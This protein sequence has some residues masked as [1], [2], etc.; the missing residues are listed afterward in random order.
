MILHKLKTFAF[1]LF[2]FAVSSSFAQTPLKNRSENEVKMLLCNNWH[3]VADET[4]GK[5]TIV[6]ATKKAY[7]NFRKDGILIM[8]NP[9][10]AREVCRWHYEH[11]ASRINILI[12]GEKDFFTIVNISS[13]ELVLLHTSENYPVKIILNR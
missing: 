5:K 4:D 3:I 6:S 12:M 1:F 10:N 13:T 11:N 2:S 9:G 7:M 8:A